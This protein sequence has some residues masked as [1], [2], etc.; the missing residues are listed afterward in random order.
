MIIADFFSGFLDKFFIEAFT[1]THPKHTL[2][3]LKISIRYA[4]M[5]RSTDVCVID[6]LE[7]VDELPCRCDF[8]TTHYAAFNN[9]HI[10]DVSN[11]HA[12]LRLEIFENLLCSFQD[13][14]NHLFFLFSSEQSKHRGLFPVSDC[15]F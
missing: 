4:E 9:I 7:F 12:N 13:V 8:S 5:G 3:L 10:I 1:R 11:L 15:H 14:K 2:F 6:Y